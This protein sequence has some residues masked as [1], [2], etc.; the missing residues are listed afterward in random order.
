MKALLVYLVFDY[1]EGSTVYLDLTIMKALLVY[2]VFDYNEG[3]TG[4]FSILTIMKALLVILI[5]L[6]FHQEVIQ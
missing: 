5:C 1:N 6:T 3:S 2:L 4:I